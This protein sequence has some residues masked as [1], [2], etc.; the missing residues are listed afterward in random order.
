MKLLSGKTI[1]LN[2]FPTHVARTRNKKAPNKY[3]KVTNQSVYNGA[4]NRFTRNNVITNMHEYIIENIPKNFGKFKG[5]VKPV[6]HIYT[7]RNHGTVKRKKDTGEHIWKPVADDYQANWDDDNLAFLWIKTIKDTLSKVGAWPDDNVDY[8]RGAD[9]DIIFV[10]T[11]E[12][13]KIVIN[14]IP[15]D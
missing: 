3:M 11:L 14:F 8:C 10:D 4:M 2:K 12:E 5:P 1:I 7:V 9:W 6:F 13:R 15:L